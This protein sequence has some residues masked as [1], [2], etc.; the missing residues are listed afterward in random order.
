[1]SQPP[2]RWLKRTILRKGLIAQYGNI[3]NRPRRGAPTVEGIIRDEET[4]LQVWYHGEW[5]DIPT[6]HIT[7]DTT[8]QEETNVVPTR[9]FFTQNESKS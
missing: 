9:A 2:L 5:M 7:I 8:N 1:M 4:V 6:E 3:S